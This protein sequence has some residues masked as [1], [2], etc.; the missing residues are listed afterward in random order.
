MPTIRPACEDVRRTSP[1]SGVVDAMSPRDHYVPRH[2]YPRLRSSRFSAA[3]D[4]LSVAADRQPR[5]CLT[6]AE[7]DPSLHPTGAP[8]DLG[9]KRL[10][11]YGAW[12]RR[13]IFFDSRNVRTSAPYTR[14]RPMPPAWSFLTYGD[15]N[16]MRRQRYARM[17]TPTAHRA[18]VSLTTTVAREPTHRFVRLTPSPRRH[19]PPMRP[20]PH[21][22]TLVQQLILSLNGK[23]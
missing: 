7:A 3:T 23:S 20:L 8:K 14:G 10:Q 21:V 9:N 22:R 17:R 16:C 18:T 6:T 2:R 1:A 5:L 11:T 4:P 19:V 13:P 15:T 12:R